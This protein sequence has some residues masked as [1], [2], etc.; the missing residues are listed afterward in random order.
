[1]EATIPT[2]KIWNETNYRKLKETNAENKKNKIEEEELGINF[3]HIQ[4]KAEE[5]KMKYEGAKTKEEKTRIMAVY[6][7]QVAGLDI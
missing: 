3:E 7:L 5:C 4:R 2:E 1:M 6:Y